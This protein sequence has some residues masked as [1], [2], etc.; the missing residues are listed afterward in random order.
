[1]TRFDWT[2]QACQLLRDHYANR[3]TSEVATI[4]GNGCSTS[5]CYHKAHAL[6]LRK[7]PEYLQSSK[8]GRLLRGVRNS[9]GTEFKPGH[10]PANKGK[11]MLPEVYAKCAPTMFKKGELNGEARHNYKPI[12]SMKVTRDGQLV[13][14]VTD[15]PSLYPAQRWVPVTRLVWEAANGAVPPGHIVRFKD[16]MHTTTAS[17]IT[18]DRLECITK[19]ENMRRN[20]IHNL[21]PEL[22][23][24]SR[25]IG[26]VTRQ[27]NKRA[28]NEKQA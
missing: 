8:S 9:P 11:P 22:A 1:M 13:R 23:D 20:T 21:P 5:T 16:G 25:L 18:V 26:R 17:E 14:K 3:S 6:G 15:D 28:K 12:G 4:I 7:S 24:T 2:E 19:A 10:V 27:I